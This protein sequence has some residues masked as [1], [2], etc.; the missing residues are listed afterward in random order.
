MVGAMNSDECPLC[1]RSNVRPGTRTLYEV[2]VCRRCR[3]RFAGLRQWA[4]LADVYLLG[5]VLMLILAGLLQTSMTDAWI[6]LVILCVFVLFAFREAIKG[7]SFGKF[8][9]GLRV[10]DRVTSTPIRP[11]QS[12]FRNAPILGFLVFY[13]YGPYLILISP[14]QR[15]VTIPQSSSYFIAAMGLLFICWQLKKGTRWGDGWARTK[16]IWDRYADRPPFDTRRLVCPKC[17]YNL[18]GVTKRC[19]ECGLAMPPENP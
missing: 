1:Q 13:L 5:V 8:I 19:P 12:L 15:Y 18:T 4:F 10:V 7:K 16:V 3:R 11:M 17:E 2:A 9:F 14:V 6:R